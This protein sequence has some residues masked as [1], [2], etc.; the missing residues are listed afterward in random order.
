MQFIT[1]EIIAHTSY[2][3]SFS[4][5]NK[6]VLNLGSFADNG[7]NMINLEFFLFSIFTLDPTVC[8][9]VVISS[10]HFDAI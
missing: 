9:I 10:V 4:S 8:A 2:K 5:N 7:I 6:A 1:T 3:A